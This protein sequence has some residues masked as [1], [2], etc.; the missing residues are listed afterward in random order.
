MDAVQVS[1]RFTSMYKL[2]GW[3]YTTLID[4]P[5]FTILNK[6]DNGTFADVRQFTVDEPSV[7]NIL[8]SL[9]LYSGQS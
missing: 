1:A 5:V 3:K 9:L 6:S 8:T 4:C 2:Q 7:V